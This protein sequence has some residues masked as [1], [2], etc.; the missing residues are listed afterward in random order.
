M[1]DPDGYVDTSDSVVLRHLYKPLPANHFL[2][3]SGSQALVDRGM[4]TPFDLV[5][6]SLIQARKI[7]LISYP[8]EWTHAQLWDAA[9]A[10]LVLAE[11]AVSDGYELKDATAFNVLFHCG[12]AEYCDHLSFVPLQD[13]YWWAY[14]QFLRHFIAPLALSKLRQVPVSNAFKAGIDG[15]PIE[16][17]RQQLGLRRWSHRVALSM[18]QRG[19]SSML[20]P[21]PHQQASVKHSSTLKGLFQ[22]LHW[23]LDG[24]KQSQRAR[25]TWHDYEANRVHYN[26]TDL[27]AKRDMVREWLHQLRPAVVLDLGCNQGE[28]SVLACEVAERVVAVD[29]DEP[30]IDQLY[31]A[32]RDKALPIQTILSSLDDP[33]PARGWCGAE[34]SS[35]N[36]RLKAHSDLVMVLALAH[37]L[38]VGN[39]LAVESVIEWLASLTRSHLIYELIAPDDVKV[40]EMAASRRRTDVADAF[41]IER[42]RSALA[43]HFDVVHECELPHSGRRLLLLQ[44]RVAA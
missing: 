8:Y 34:F 28:F 18:L 7:P 43:R 19:H 10:T 21:S 12:R 14:G 9:H 25:T 26:G 30:S 39:G 16:Q 44:R 15:V 38:V 5:G 32:V 13:P 41:A 31:Q 23:Q 37:H 1:R 6:E 20:P 24:L 4:L 29:S 27:E 33:T 17:C 11:A 22:F 42:Q 2:R 36:E 3:T 35:L 40:S